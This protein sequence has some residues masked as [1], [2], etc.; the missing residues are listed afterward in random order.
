MLDTLTPFN[1]DDFNQ[2]YNKSFGWYVCPTTQKKLLVYV[3]RVDRDRVS[4]L[5]DSGE[6]FAYAGTDVFFEFLPI[7]RGW[8]TTRSLP[9]LLQRVP[10]KQ[11]CRGISE[12]N[13]SVSSFLPDGRLTEVELTLDKLQD[14][15]TPVAKPSFAAFLDHPEKGFVINP[16]FTLHGFALYFYGAVIGTRKDQSI[17]LTNFLVKQELEDA[18]RRA[19][20]PLVVA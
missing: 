16:F 4:F 10:A 3:K 2:R 8:F 12:Q 17:T 15:F 11:F 14:V 5:S 20:L 13:T 7:T 18:I 1:R 6:Y 19:A 9:I